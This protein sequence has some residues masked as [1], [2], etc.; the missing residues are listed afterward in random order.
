MIV[1]AGGF[2]LGKMEQDFIHKS[3]PHFLYLHIFIF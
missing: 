3:Q 1:K 2:V